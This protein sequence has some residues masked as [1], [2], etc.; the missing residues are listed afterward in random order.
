MAVV[1]TITMLKKMLMVIV[2]MKILLMLMGTLMIRTMIPTM[3]LMVIIL[4][5]LSPCTGTWFTFTD[6]KE[7]L[8]TFFG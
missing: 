5:R 6:S 3:N 8:I 7:I 4:K 1:A 2:M